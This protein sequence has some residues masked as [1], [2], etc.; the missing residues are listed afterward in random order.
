MPYERDPL[1]VRYDDAAGRL[2]GRAYAAP[3]TW[4]YSAI[5]EPAGGRYSATDAG[6]LKAFERAF[7]RSL[8][9]VHNGGANGRRNRVWSL[10]REWGPVTEHGRLVGVRVSEVGTARRALARKPSTAWWKHPELRSGGQGA[11][12][13]RFA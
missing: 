9:Y 6:G 1:S 13:Q 12:G 7:Q 4:Q 5:A 3:G 10:Q 11:P 2:L 8:Y